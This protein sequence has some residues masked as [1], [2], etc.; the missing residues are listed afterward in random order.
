MEN[1][2]NYYQL[3]QQNLAD[4][5]MRG[6]YFDKK[7]IGNF[8][9]AHPIEL[10]PILHSQLSVDYISYTL[11]FF[12]AGIALIWSFLP[13][14]LFSVFNI[15]TKKGFS[16]MG[17]VSIKTPGL[18]ITLFFVF[19]YIF[20]F[21]FF[22]FLVIKAYAANLAS[23]GN[24]LV[25]TAYIFIAIIL[26]YLFKIIYIKLSGFIFNTSEKAMQQLG[27]YINTENAFGV[28]LIPVL[29][30]SLYSP[31]HYILFAGILLFFIFLVI[32]WVKTFLIGLSIGGFSVLHLILYLCALEIIPVLVV[33]KLVE[34]GGIY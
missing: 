32:R 3:I 21:G 27:I 7:F 34:N 22:I 1:T 10:E 20:N 24:R 30:L 15:S 5:S 8:I 14:R 25:I 9:Q 19:N 18:L 16:R 12:T 11:L 6:T 2:L 17:D 33:I 31:A 26:F 23:G 13:E 29:I 28:L 4:S